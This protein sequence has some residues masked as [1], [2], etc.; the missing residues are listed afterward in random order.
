MPRTVRVR[1]RG[2]CGSGR[3]RMGAAHPDTAGRAGRPPAGFPR[4]RRAVT[5]PSQR[6][7]PF[8]PA[9]IAYH[10]RRRQGPFRVAGGQLSS[11]AVTPLPTKPE[12]GT[13]PR[14]ADP[15][16]RSTWEI[17][18]IVVVMTPTDH[19]GR[20]GPSASSVT[21]TP[22]VK[23]IWSGVQQAGSGQK[24]LRVWNGPALGAGSRTTNARPRHQRSR[25]SVNFRIFWHVL[26]TLNSTKSEQ[27]Y[28]IVA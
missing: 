19:P 25:R 3:C 9:S 13:R 16:N 27:L 10:I 7:A 20:T 5:P 28:W 6:R 23:G 12:V 18:L 26:F 4:P 14:R 24:P 17:S 1:C 8:M 15:A 22:A 2:R 21:V 11:P